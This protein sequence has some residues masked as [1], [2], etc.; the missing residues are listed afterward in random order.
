MLKIEANV[1]RRIGA[2][3]QRQLTPD[4]KRIVR[5]YFL[6]LREAGRPKN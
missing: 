5:D 1:R 6:N 4:L 3:P 2:V